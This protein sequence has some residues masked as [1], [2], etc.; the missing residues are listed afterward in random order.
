MAVRD[1]GRRRRLAALVAAVT[2]GLTAVLWW[3]SRSPGA[4]VAVP[5]PLAASPS[6]P[7]QEWPFA[8]IE[9]TLIEPPAAGPGRRDPLLGAISGE[10]RHAVVLE[11][12][13]LVHS[14][15]GRLWLG[16]AEDR[17]REEAFDRLRRSGM[18]P[19]VDM[20][21]AAFAWGEESRL[22]VAASGHF[23]RVDPAVL[24]RSLLD[25][26]RQAPVR[27]HG[28]DAVV[29]DGEFCFIGC[30]PATL[31]AWRGRTLILSY[32]EQARASVD[33]LQGRSDGET[34]AF[35]SS[36]E[37]AEVLGVVSGRDVAEWLELDD[38]ALR[39]WL[40]ALATRAEVRVDAMRDLRAEA[41]VTVEDPA[42]AD[43]LAELFAAA[44]A[45]KRAAAREGGEWK[46]AELLERVTVIRGV[47]WFTLRL[48]LPLDALERQFAG[49]RDEARH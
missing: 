16:C 18:E 42:A 12:N 10:Y 2:A 31:A 32:P 3:C 44:V 29:V 34:F 6:G 49:C 23:G 22:L 25:G 21:R 15:L 38:P 13:A 47:G 20:D 9:V 1:R 11:V 35:P 48:D 28:S 33:L 5:A 43:D 37:P 26:E 46:R 4:E 41:R 17:D 19:L 39:E 36:L 8:P 7:P 30:R 40:R 14:P 27:P 24:A 45:A